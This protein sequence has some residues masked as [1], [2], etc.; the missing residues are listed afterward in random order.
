[1]R[2]LAPFRGI[3]STR[4]RFTFDLPTHSL[5]LY[6]DIAGAAFFNTTLNQP[7]P[8]SF[9]DEQF[10]SLDKCL[11]QY[12]LK[13]ELLAPTVNEYRMAGNLSKTLDVNV[14]V[15]RNIREPQ[16]SWSLESKTCTVQ[17]E[18]LLPKE[19]CDSLAAKRPVGLREKLGL[20]STPSDF[21][22]KALF[23]ASIGYP[24]VAVIGEPVN[25]QLHVYHHDEA[26]TVTERP[27]VHLRKV[28]VWLRNETSICALR[29]RN[30]SYGPSYNLEQV[31]WKRNTEIFMRNFDGVFPR[32]EQLDLRNVMN[33]E[34]DSSLVPT[35]KTF[36]IARTYSLR[37]N[38]QIQ[39]LGKEYYIFGNDTRCTL[40]SKDYAP[41]PSS[42]D[43]LMPRVVVDGE[44]LDEPP[45]PYESIA[46]DRPPSAIT[47][48]SIPFYQATSTASTSLIPASPPDLVSQRRRS[49]GSNVPSLVPRARPASTASASV[50]AIGPSLVV[51]PMVCSAPFEEPRRRSEDRDGRLPLD[52]DLIGPSLTVRGSHNRSRSADHNSFAAQIPTIFATR[53]AARGAARGSAALRQAAMS[54]SIH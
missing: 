43:L 24:S 37:V 47:L 46:G 27:R 39:C 10:G 15:F 16:I 19:H 38:V 23:T 14:S 9:K 4:F 42:G 6:E 41:T 11:I 51:R 25:L 45:P 50:T 20:K 17:T 18:E 49:E 26:S 48:E 32:V 12:Q 29:P 44:E 3:G 2:M 36:N 7:L 52:V 54:S 30:A 40:L 8:P 5:D 35:F 28:Q 34:L 33:L 22:R 13:A 53:H 21:Y 1:M 31:G